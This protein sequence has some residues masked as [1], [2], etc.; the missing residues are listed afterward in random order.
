MIDHN[1]IEQALADLK[2]DDPGIRQ[3][4]I[5]YLNAVID[6]PE[7]DDTLRLQ[8]MME[9]AAL[10][11]AAL[12]TGADNTTPS[13]E[14]FGT[15]GDLDA[16]DEEDSDAAWLDNLASS[17]NPDYS[18]P[19][20]DEPEEDHSAWLDSLTQSHGEIPQKLSSMTDVMP[21]EFVNEL[22][23]DMRAVNEIPEWLNDMMPS[24]EVNSGDLLT[25]E[26]E[27]QADETVELPEWLRDDNIA[28]LDI[29]SADA[30]TESDLQERPRHVVASPAPATTDIIP[31]APPMP[32][33][34]APIH[35]D[36]VQF[37][38]YH[39]R[40]INP[41]VW[42]PFYAYVFYASAGSDVLNDA[43][44]ALGEKSGNYNASTAN[45]A[46]SIPHGTAI[47]ATP[48]VPGFQ[49]N[50]LSMTVQFDE[51]W[52]RFDFKIKAK[53]AQ[54]NQFETGRVTFTIDGIIVADVPI[55]VY[56]GESPRT[57]EVQSTRNPLYTSIFCSY[58]HTDAHIVQRVERA[59]QA[60][61]IDYLRDLTTLKSGTH[62]SDELLGMIDRADVFQLFWSQSAAL[63][64]YV[65]QEYEHAL[66]Y[67]LQ[68]HNFIR[69]VCWE[70]PL[71][72]IPRK[73]SHIHF[74]Y[75]PELHLLGD[76]ATT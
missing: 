11:S 32:A 59:Y 6:E 17:K 30:K 65:R 26:F 63:S 49:F 44:R 70:N 33:P 68:R 71:P 76:K 4:A 56:V 14:S 7:L 62:W 54:E 16:L 47:T 45:A 31:T 67:D 29:V 40:T 64:P 24:Q 51:A 42:E 28:T 18:P 53:I 8:I 72:M 15:N 23:S 2:S 10:G 39:P 48:Y 34:P 61:G 5:T 57:V 22:M 46:Q 73:L 75:H 3:S 74:A 12:A 21:S 27:I 13:L 55:A 41:Q 35:G 19:K 20:A 66:K 58:S 36:A 43:M 1:R 69:P 52:S 25:E 37:S 9:I 60:L 50:P 38:A